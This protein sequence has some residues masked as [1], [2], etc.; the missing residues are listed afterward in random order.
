MRTAAGG[1]ARPPVHRDG[2]HPA[3]GPEDGD[4]QEERDDE[5]DGR[6]EDQRYQDLVDQ[7][8]PLE[9]A[10]PLVSDHGACEPADEGVRRARGNAAP[11]R[12]QVPGARADE[13]GKGR[14]PG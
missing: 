5:A 4:R 14:Q 9:S 8:V 2:A 12:E 6:R 11:P 1:G 10:Q 13:R 3:H 7:R